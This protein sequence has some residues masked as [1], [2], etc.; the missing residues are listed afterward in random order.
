MLETGLPKGSEGSLG[1]FAKYKRSCMVQLLKVRE[2]GESQCLAPRTGHRFL[3]K[4]GGQRGLEG[5][6]T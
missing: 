2:G 1:R 3:L 4:R 5:E 6:R